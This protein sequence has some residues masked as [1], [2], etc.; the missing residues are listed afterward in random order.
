M[1]T[2]LRPYTEYE[3]QVRF[4]NNNEPSPWSVLDTVRT[5]EGAPSSPRNVTLTAALSNIIEIGWTTPEFVNGILDHYVVR[6]WGT[7]DEDNPMV[8]NTTTDMYIIVNLQDNTNYSVQIAAVTGAGHGNYSVI[9]TIETK[10]LPRFASTNAITVKVEATQATITWQK[11]NESTDI[12]DGPVDLYRVYYKET[13][14]INWTLHQNITVIDPSNTSYSTT[15]SGLQWSTSYDFTV[16]VKRP[17]PRGEGSK[18]TFTTKMTLCDVP[19]QG[20]VIL[21][22]TSLQ[23]TII[24]IYIEMPLPENIKCNHIDNFEIRHREINSGDDYE[25]SA[26]RDVTARSFTITGL[27]PYT[28][29]DV[30]VRFNNSNAASPWRSAPAVIRTAQGVPSMPRDVTL[31]SH[32]YT[33]HVEW[34]IP[35]FLNGILDHY[36][37]TYWETGHGEAAHNE[38]TPGTNYKIASLQENVNYTVQIGAVTGAGLGDYSEIQ[39]IETKERPRFSSQNLPQVRVQ[40][41]QATISWQKWDE[42]TDIGAGPVEAYKVYYKQTGDNDWTLY[43]H[44]TVQD[45]SQTSYSTLITGLQWSTS[46][47]FTVTVKRPGPNGEGSKD[48]VTVTTLC[49]VPERPII[50]SAVSPYPRKIE[51]NIEE[52]TLPMIKCNQQGKSGYIKLFEV[53]YKMVNNGSWY[54]TKSENDGSS[55][56]FVLKDLTPYTEYRVQIR[57]NNTDEQS[58]WSSPENVTTKEGVPSKPRNVTLTAAVYTIEVQWL[59]P[60][61]LNGVLNQY[62]ISYWKTGDGSRT[63]VNVT[64]DL[65]DVTS[66]II[67]NLEYKVNY[68]VQI[69]GVTGGGQ[70]LF[71]NVVTIQTTK[72]IP[73]MPAS[74]EIKHITDDSIKLEWEEPAIFSGDIEHYGMRYI[75]R[76]TVFRSMVMESKTVLVEGDIHTYTLTNLAAGTKYEI[77]LNASTS[78]GFGETLTVSTGTTFTVDVSE[79]LTFSGDHLEPISITDS[80]AIVTL[81]QLS[82]DTTLSSNSTLLDYII[83]VEYDEI[84]AKR[85]KRE[86][87]PDQLSS[88]NN[89]NVPY[90][91]TASIPLEDLA[92]TF[93][94]GDGNVYDGYFNAP[95][96]PTIQYYIYYGFASDVT[97][98]IVYSLEDEPRTSFK[99]AGPTRGISPPIGAIIGGILAPLLVLGIIIGVVFF[100]RRMNSRKTGKDTQEE[101]IPCIE[102]EKNDEYAEPDEITKHVNTALGSESEHP[103]EPII[104]DTNTLRMKPDQHLEPIDNVYTTVE[105]ES[106]STY[107]S[108]DNT[109]RLLD[110]TITVANIKHAFEKLKSV[111]S[112]TR[113]TPLQLE[114]ET[115]NKESPKPNPGEC[116]SGRLPKNV[117]KNRDIDILPIDT[118]RPKLLTSVR[119]TTDYINASFVDAYTR[120]DAFLVTQMPL[121]D[122]VVDFWRMVYDHKSYTIVMLNDMDSGNIVDGQY[123]PSNSIQ[124]YGP[125]EVEMLSKKQTGNIVTRVF[126]LSLDNNESIIIKQF[127]LLVWLSGGENQAFKQAIFEVMEKV[128]KW[129]NQTGKGSVTVHCINGIGRSGVYCAAVS[130]CERA[131]EEQIV[132]VFQ[133]VKTARMKRPKMVEMMDEY[134]LCYEVVVQYCNIQFAAYANLSK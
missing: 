96:I 67:S 52:L 40:A 43:Q 14:Y 69:A 27:R 97:G 62:I 7:G 31:T 128:E 23:P 118:Y 72:T 109:T 4:I 130:A 74:I 98:E 10:E 47:D 9:H 32:L 131:K 115:L 78:K 36:V 60:E 34:V 95:L 82:K 102:I 86:V 123:W 94:I 127:Q 113:K 29:Y 114:W 99:A 68:N 19:E 80:T 120:K 65:L 50:Q 2:K 64:D 54:E 25:Y 15:I 63:M 119:N 75:S 88:Y 104:P 30:E 93:T 84:S 12:G 53:R 111:N 59:I 112:N 101:P 92:K 132:D 73:G 21:N 91:I 3:V 5:A 28:E 134:Q 17:G 89:T 103:Y 46:Y 57:Y 51:I 38:S 20:P 70:G 66:Y 71:S 18:D 117:K 42:S 48:K 100:I 107:V 87:D 108:L 24:R 44:F 83:V 55:R 11:W 35:E 125:F 76:E 116:K 122:T 49:G 105:Q 33:I 81:P 13:A 56:F 121:P 129:Q 79:E 133:A 124:H 22:A 85:K 26:E 16:T 39:T 77:Y 1:L 90:Y 37:V 106:P 61:F 126:Q 45:P 8:E 58:P 6:Y 41:I 110:T